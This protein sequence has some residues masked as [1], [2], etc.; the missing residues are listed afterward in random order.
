[1][2]LD[3]NDPTETEE[4]VASLSVG[5]V[6]SQSITY[7]LLAVLLRALLVMVLAGACWLVYKKLPSDGA[8]DPA[9]AGSGQ[10]TVQIILRPSSEISAAALDIPVE[11][12][13]V[14]LL[15]VRQEYQAEPHGGKRFDEFR[16]ERMNGRS[17]V[18]AK[19]NSRGEAFLVIPPG[20]WW[21]HAVLSA[22]EDLEWR[23]PVTVTGHKQT[24]EL[25]P[26]NAYTRSKSF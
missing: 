9:P 22:N 19:L 12:S 17:S 5:N 20:N 15:A 7:R 24:V 10:T 8:G 4:C 25:T 16:N 18:T 23:L 21:V 1:M 26:Q 6:N 2:L 13:P 14:D 11:I 3:Y